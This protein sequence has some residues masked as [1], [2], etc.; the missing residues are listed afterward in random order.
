MSAVELSFSNLESVPP[1]PEKLGV[2]IQWAVSGALVLCLIAVLL[3]LWP[4]HG[5]PR[6]AGPGSS[7]GCKLVT[8]PNAGVP[9]QAGY[10]CA[11][12]STYYPEQPGGAMNY[13]KRRTSHQLH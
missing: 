7:S 5:V 8:F 9:Y 3:A 12:G 4:E 13:P 10:Q 11:D 1:H 6:H 2:A